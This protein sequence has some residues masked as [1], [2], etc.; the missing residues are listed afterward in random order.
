MRAIAIDTNTYVGF[1]RGQQVCLEV[2]QR[3][4]RLLISSTVLGELLAGFACGNKERQNRAELD[5]FLTSERVE[6][7]PAVTATAEAYARIFHQLRTQGSPIPSN[8]IW[9]AA[10]SLEEG[11]ALFTFDA[12]FQKV[13]GLVMGQSW[14]DLSP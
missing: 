11:A 6:I 9:I 4:D 7:R 2:F 1:K 12:H 8:D 3:A 5:R 13:S 14:D 10:S